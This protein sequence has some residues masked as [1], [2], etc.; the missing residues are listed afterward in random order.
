MIEKNVPTTTDNKLQEVTDLLR[1]GDQGAFEY[2]YKTY[3]YKIFLVAYRKT[4]SKETAEELVQ[5]LFLNLWKKR[6]YL[7]ILQLENYLFSSIK[8]SIFAFYSS[9]SLENKYLESV[10][11]KIEFENSGVE[12]AMAVNDINIAINKGLDTLPDKTRKVFHMSRFENLSV[13]EIAKKLKLSDKAVEYHLTKS[14]K[15]L[16]TLLKDFIISI[17]ILVFG[18]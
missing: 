17:L 13:H 7:E 3:W 14:L 1:T 18:Y 2:I 15:V 12:E 10:R 4:K 9:Q 11:N 8:Y 16:K 6:E 5:E